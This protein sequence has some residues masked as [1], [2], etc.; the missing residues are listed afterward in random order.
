MAV[1]TVLSQVVTLL[2]NLADTFFVGHTNEPVQIAALTL[3]FPLFM[4]LTMLGNLFGIGANSL[5]SRSLGR[6][7][8]QMPSETSVLALWG[9]LA[10][11]L[12]WIALLS[13]NKHSILMLVGANSPG[14]YY[15]TWAYLKWTVVFGGMPTVASMV[16]AH[17]IRGEGNT[18]QAAKG[19]AIG[20]I[21]NIALDPIFVQLLDMGAE[22]AGIATFISNDVS[23]AYL[24]LT[25]LRSDNTV[26]EFNPFRLKFKPEIFKETLLVGLPAA[27]VI[28]LGATANIVLTNCMSSHGEISLAAFGIVQK[29]GAVTIQ[30]TIGLTQGIMPL[31]GYYYGAGNNGKVKEIS[32]WSFMIVGTFA[33]LIVITAELFPG[34]IIM[35]FT[36]DEPVVSLGASFLRVWILCAFGMCFVN[37]ISSIFQATGKWEKALALSIMRQAVLFIPFIIILHKM[38]GLQG[39][40]I[41]QPAADTFALAI[42]FAMYYRSEKNKNRAAQ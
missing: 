14:T 5:I 8:K 10:L 42:G 18:A 15:A 32:H 12:L 16:I 25:L 26:V 34:D 31:Y 40:I 4:S 3:S 36:G 6:N 29:L 9:A 33:L 22:G 28:V 41:S 27:A 21:L 20:G 7:D 37:L 24:L 39:I 23:L 38:F 30:I 17:C 13:A 11:T 2:Y 35:L 19:I 1:P